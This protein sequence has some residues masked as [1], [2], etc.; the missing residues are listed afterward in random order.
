MQIVCLRQDFPSAVLCVLQAPDEMAF[1]GSR[2]LPPSASGSS[3]GCIHALKRNETLSVSAAGF[4]GFFSLSFGQQ[5]QSTFGEDQK[6]R[7]QDV[8][9]PRVCRALALVFGALVCVCEQLQGEWNFCL[10]DEF[11][12]G[13]AVGLWGGKPCFWLGSPK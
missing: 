8:V 6:I 5:V 7:T 12:G 9:Q 10:A 1:S 13:W 11:G 3:S 2:Y 4:I